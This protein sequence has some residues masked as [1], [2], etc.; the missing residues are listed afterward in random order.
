[1][2]TQLFTRFCANV[3]WHWRLWCCWLCHATLYYFAWRT[4]LVLSVSIAPLPSQVGSTRL[5]WS[6][7]PF[8]LF[9]PHGPVAL[10]PK[11]AIL[12]R[13]PPYG[14]L[15]RAERS[16]AINAHEECAY[17]LAGEEGRDAVQKII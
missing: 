13:R 16:T 6:F 10:G 1:M 17:G 3:G 15:L 14:R 2:I 9:S 5:V 8:V 4:A 11:E 12:D 7:K